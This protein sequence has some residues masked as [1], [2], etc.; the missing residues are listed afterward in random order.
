[1]SFLTMVCKL[2]IVFLIESLLLISSIS[3]ISYI[4][5]SIIDRVLLMI[6][7]NMLLSFLYFFLK[8]IYI[9]L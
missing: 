9:C 3:F 7:I 8:L 5:P 1:M 4:S 2:V 6:G